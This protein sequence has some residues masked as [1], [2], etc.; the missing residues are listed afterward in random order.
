[1][2]NIKIYAKSV[3]FQW[4]YK[5]YNEDYNAFWKH[6]ICARCSRL[7]DKIKFSPPSVFS[8]NKIVYLI[9]AGLSSQKKFN[10]IFSISFKKSSPG[11]GKILS[12]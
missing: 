5:L 9:F 4:I 3:K 6:L 7:Q 10:I 2:T 11:E 8:L 12:A 1:L